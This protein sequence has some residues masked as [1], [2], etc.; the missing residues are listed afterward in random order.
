LG[1]GYRCNGDGH[2]KRSDWARNA[3]EKALDVQGKDPDTPLPAFNAIAVRRVVAKWTGFA[4]FDNGIIAGQY[5][6]GK[7]DNGKKN[8]HGF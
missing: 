5:W 2:P 7:Q 8:F 3:Q 4:H 1:T 6:H